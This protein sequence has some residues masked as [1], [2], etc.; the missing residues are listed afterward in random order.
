MSDLPQPEPESLF[1]VVPDRAPAARRSEAQ[2]AP[3][4]RRKLRV[5]IP[6]AL[7]D[8]LKQAVAVLPGESLDALVEEALARIVAERGAP[9]A[10]PVRRRYD[11]SI[12]VI[13]P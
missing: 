9:A 3:E 6:T 13:L 10:K 8:E 12:L 5:T 2:P 11:S 1:V 4:P 7:A